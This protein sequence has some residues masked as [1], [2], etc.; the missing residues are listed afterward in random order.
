[1]FAD[2]NN[3]KT[4]KEIIQNTLAAHKLE[5]LKEITALRK[6]EYERNNAEEERRREVE[7]ER[8]TEENDRKRQENVRQQE[9]HE[10]NMQTQK[11]EVI[12]KML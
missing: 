2:Q 11:I 9:Q 4:E 7:N 5:Y 1:M 10:V 6:E 8:K 3:K 12:Q